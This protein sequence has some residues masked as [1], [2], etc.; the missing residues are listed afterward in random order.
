[1]R[2]ID[3]S[4]IGA[5][6]L[7]SCVSA[8]VIAEDAVEQSKE[9]PLDQIWAYEMPGTRDIR[10]LE[11]KLDV[12]DPSFR[13]L[14]RRSLVRQIASFLSTYVPKE[15][16]LARPAF[17]VVGTGK[18]AL[19]NAHA[20]F[21]K[22]RLAHGTATVPSDTE[23]SLVFYTYVTGWHPQINSVS[24][25]LDTI[26]VKYQFISPQEPAFGAKRFALI[27][28]GKLAPGTVQVEIE[29]VPPMDY[30]GRPVEW[31]TDAERFVCGSF[32]F[33]VK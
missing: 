27:P 3:L 33:D 23:L 6:I 21:I 8:V 14:Y 32:S 28:I 26:T 19:K 22:E 12:H 10:E 31:K 13:D 18:E 9:I 30:R 15:S 20:I 29:Q 7:A 4:L 25:S 11:P 2:P 5:C 17:V 16:E 1:M 24:Q